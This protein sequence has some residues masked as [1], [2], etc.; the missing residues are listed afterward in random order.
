MLVAAATSFVSCL[1][2]DV[3]MDDPTDV[4]V[5][6]GDFAPACDDGIVMVEATCCT[7]SVGPDRSLDS[8]AGCCSSCCCSSQAPLFVWPPTWW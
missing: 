6:A 2:P 1:I 7:L 3:A 5:D 4:S 8:A